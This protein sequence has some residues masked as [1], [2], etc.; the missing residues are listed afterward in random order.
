MRFSA[1]AC[2]ERQVL[3]VLH[4]SLRRLLSSFGAIYQC[5]SAYMS[6]EALELIERLPH[7]QRAS[8][9]S[10]QQKGRA[11]FEMADYEQVLLYQL[12]LYVPPI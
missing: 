3:T 7:N 9:W 1:I 10:L 4:Q 2:A 8:G 5:I 6:L 11:Y 12:L